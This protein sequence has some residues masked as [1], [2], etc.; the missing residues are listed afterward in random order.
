MLKLAIAV[1][2][3]GLSSASAM[4]LPMRIN[5]Q[6][7]LINP[8][9]SNPQTGPVSLTFNIYNAATG[10]T[11]LYT[12]TQTG[13]ALTN[14]VFSVQIGAV[15]ALSR[16][17]FVGATAYLG[18]T[19]VG[20]A[21]GEMTPRQSLVMSPY[22]FT[23][24]QLSDGANVRLIA[25]LAYSTFTS[26]GNLIVPAG[27]TASSGTFTATGA[28][29]Y[30]L[31]LST[32]VSFVQG[33]P[34]VGVLWADGT[35]STTAAS[36]SG[37]LSSVSATAALTGSGTAASP[38]GVNSSSVP[39]FGTNGN[40]TLPYGVIVGTVTLTVANSSITSIGGGLNMIETGDTFGS[41]AL[42][43]EDRNGSNG[44][45][46]RQLGTV[47]LVDFGFVGL[48]NQLN[49]RME[50]RSG[51]TY[52][53][54]AYQ[55]SQPEFEMGTAGNPSFDVGLAA[56]AFR[57]PLGIGTLTPN[58]ELQ[59]QAAAGT[60]GRIFLNNSDYV[61]GSAGSGLYL[62]MA[63]ASGST[64]SVIQS[65][66]NGN[67]VPAIL[68][69][70]PYNTGAGVGIGNTA[71]AEALDVTGNVRAQHFRGSTGTPTYTAGTGAGTGPTITIAGNDAAGTI[72]VK[73]GTGP[74]ASATLVTVTFNTAYGTAPYVTLTPGSATTAL[75]G[76][77]TLAGLPATPVWVSSTTGAFTLT[78]TTTALAANTTYVWVY[79][80]TQ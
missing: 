23:A 75:L 73:T 80:V 32:S 65:F 77:Y 62:A 18:V 55:V 31:T 70:N 72:T 16:D 37:G 33:T 17:L 64:Y 7:K 26:A 22:A 43:L 21:G 38:L 13:V 44:A 48:N 34:G 20:D 2:L 29:N 74:T 14:G 47:D 63:A 68:S 40:L 67:S 50:N 6:G 78:T 69:L 52:N 79:H 61:N 56:S 46:F 8:A 49:I 27:V 5:F 35:I 28:G 9:T 36:G 10:G 57:V 53:G 45:I 39:V 51:L 66:V 60:A 1:L 19:V 3:G 25:G 24:N 30:A 59:V 15:N 12:E 41:V 42:S 71:P 11:S 76:A 58:S 54:T 4:T